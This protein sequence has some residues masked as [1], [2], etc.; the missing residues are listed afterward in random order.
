MPFRDGLS[1]MMMVEQREG[2]QEWEVDVVE[3]TRLY[4]LVQPCAASEQSSGTARI[5]FQP[6]C[7]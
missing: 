4:A 5:S 6:D 3:R 1:E 2:E 7:Y